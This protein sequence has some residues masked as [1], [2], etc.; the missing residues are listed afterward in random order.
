MDE[1][2]KYPIGRF[3]WDAAASASDRMRAIEEIARLPGM[4]KS[5]LAGLSEEQLDA[6]YRPEGWTVRQVVHHVADSHLNAFVRFRL[7]LTE[8]EP[9]IKP[10]DEK[11]WAELAD[12][13]SAPVEASVLIVQ[14]MHDRWGLLLR[15]LSDEDF[16]RRFRHPERGLM[17]LDQVTRLYAWHGRH[18]VAHITSLRERMNW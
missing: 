1:N 2:L 13:C 17:S 12:A 18:H 5:A 6:P 16:R 11:A 9:L 4:L 3:Q 8:L 10:Y 14:G 7:G 15:T